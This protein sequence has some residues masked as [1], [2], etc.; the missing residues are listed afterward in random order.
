MSTSATGSETSQGGLQ[1]GPSG[2]LKLGSTSGG[3]QL[4][5]SGGLKFGS[6]QLGSSGGGLQLGF[7]GS[8][9]LQAPPTTE[10]LK[11]LAQF[12]PAT[13]G[14][15]CDTCLVDNKK[16]DTSCVACS[17]S[18]PGSS[19]QQAPPTSAPGQLKLSGDSLLGSGSASLCSG[20]GFKL[21]GG[22]LK[23][24]LEGGLKIG[25]SEGG[26]KLGEGGLKFGAGG[27][28]N[29]GGGGV[30]V[31]GESL[32]TFPPQTTAGADSGTGV[33]QSFSGPGFGSAT[34][35]VECSLADNTKTL[36]TFA[37][38]T[39]NTKPLV[40][41]AGTT[42][43]AKPLVTF[44]GTTD[45]AKPLVTFAG[46]TDTAKPLVTFAGT[47]DTAK[48]LV[49]FAGTTDTAKPLVT[50]AGTT[51]T[52]KPLTGTSK[53]FGGEAGVKPAAFSF[54]ASGQSS[55][56]SQPLSGLTFTGAN[57]NSIPPPA[58]SCSG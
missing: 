58:S 49:T 56:S 50:F 39:D 54:S 30:N 43:T 34:S 42:D 48:P 21:G 51:D 52:T 40:T 7:S 17:T 14:W 47:T 8:Q 13:D 32:Q 20:G 46:T 57:Q 5:S 3:L 18:R 53:L 24:G 37:G 12:A 23:F 2:G 35:S 29:F 26:I 19:G 22:G 28:L 10:P 9:S 15:S 33:G 11:P 55:S 38:T 16:T 25:G 1:L 27:G 31:G 36:V 44:A 4:G 45:T 41:F 6:S